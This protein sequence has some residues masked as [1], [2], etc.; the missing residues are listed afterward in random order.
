MAV[1]EA[2]LPFERV[3]VIDDSER[4]AASL[5]VELKA[6]GFTPVGIE[7]EGRE[8]ADIIGE[9]T[10][11]ADAAVC[12]HYLSRYKRVRFTGAEA[13]AALTDVGVPA[14]LITMY[15]VDG[16]VD[17]RLHRG[18][19]PS[20]LLR[21]EAGMD[22]LAE[23]LTQ[24]Y[25]ELHTGR[26]RERVPYRTT[27]QIERISSEA[28]EAV[29]DARV[30]GWRE[31]EVVRFPIKMIPQELRPT[32]NDELVGQI[33]FA[34]VNLGATRALDLFLQDFEA[35]PETALGETLLAEAPNVDWGELEEESQ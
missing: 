31:E 27:L 18:R 30:S 16:D 32:N 2:E 7:I 13:V 19:I 12:D 22:E 25:A 9:V 10:D 6:I 8:L 15:A 1:A 17:I 3:A 11:R 4:D 35:A 34:A 5:Q 20:L 23:A 21:T 14:C 33:F 28:E 24:S 29:A 26:A